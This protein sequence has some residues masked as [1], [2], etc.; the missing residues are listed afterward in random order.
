MAAFAK[1]IETD[2]FPLGIIYKS[3]QKPTFEEGLDAYQD[4]AVA[5]SKREVQADKLKRYME[6]LKG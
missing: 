2:K 4:S 1:A 3:K 6:A 5:V